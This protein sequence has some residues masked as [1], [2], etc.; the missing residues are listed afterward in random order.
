M[1]KRISSFL[2]QQNSGSA[3]VI[4]IV[5]MAFVGIL[6]STLMWMSLM[7]FR[8]KMTDRRIKESFYTAETV[9]EQMVVGL[10]NLSSDSADQSY[11]FIMQNYSNFSEEK[12]NSEFQKEYLK[13]V[14]QAI[15]KSSTETGV[16]DLQ[17]LMLYVDAGLQVGIVTPSATKSWIGARSE[18]ITLL[19]TDD[20]YKSQYG[21]IV[22]PTGADY[23][24][25]KGLH[26]EYY[27]QNGFLTIID[28]DLMISTPDAGF[29][30]SGRVA[31]AFDY[32]IIA[33]TSLKNEA[34]SGVGTIDGSVYVGRDGITANSSMVIK[35]AEYLVSKGNVEIHKNGSFEV[36]SGAGDVPAFWAKGITVDKDVVNN[37]RVTLRAHSYIKDDLTVNGDRTTITLA[38]SY[39]GY[40]N[41]ESEVGESS[42]IIINGVNNSLNLSGVRQLL[43]AGHAFTSIQAKSVPNPS[44]LGEKTV[45]IPMGES[46]A[47]KGEQIAYL[48]PDECVGVL[49][50]QSV[51]GRNPM[52]GDQYADLIEN[53]KNQPEYSAYFKEVDVNR[54]LETYGGKSLAHYGIDEVNG[55]EKVF[56]PSNGETLVYYYLKFQSTEEA[57]RFFKDYYEIH[58][59]KMDR[60]TGL[61]AAG[62]IRSNA[63]FTRLTVAGDYLIAT[64]NGADGNSVVL[65]ESAGIKNREEDLEKEISTYR[66]TFS[67]LTTALTT[68]YL[69]LTLEE[70]ARG[71]VF[72]NLVK[73]EAL[74]A[75]VGSGTRT[76]TVEDGTGVKAILTGE[77]TYSYDGDPKVVLIIANGN[78]VLNAPFEGVI[79]ADG[80]VTMKAGASV[81]SAKNADKMSEIVRVLQTKHSNADETKPLDFIRNAQ[82]YVLAGTALTK[83]EDGYK[84]NWVDF[85]DIVSYQN[86]SKR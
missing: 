48:V 26:L 66:S 52:T 58:K 15:C 16:Y 44:S 40:G 54:Q 34:T 30:Q 23:M 36:G 37:P 68:N 33:D 11:S 5:A 81:K 53:Y 29:T 78:V 14:A 32:A 25:L 56:I 71:D 59:E 50:G 69:S 38:D 43:L 47:I 17:K 61:Y 12:R 1:K 27:D 72:E 42:A 60:Y 82:D 75:Y 62:G 39:Y 80:S 41:S 51:F 4:V 46:I 57:E 49:Y 79:F 19:G 6:A 2:R 74:D 83:D 55:I 9:F 31:N 67:G 10:Q 22:S 45:D 70:K 24:I 20:E 85:S 65:H 63:G 18:D 77:N 21:T 28:T 73:K 86:W 84:R 8:M 35:N 64:A 7:N 76:F 13:A 3:I